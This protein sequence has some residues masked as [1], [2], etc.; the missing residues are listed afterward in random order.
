LPEVSKIIQAFA[1]VAKT[2]HV[3]KIVMNTHRYSQIAVAVVAAVYLM[4]AAPPGLR[5][6]AAESAGAAAPGSATPQSADGKSQGWDV[7]PPCVLS[8]MSTCPPGTEDFDSLDL[9][10]LHLLGIPEDYRS[11]VKPKGVR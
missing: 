5:V 7:K 3:E 8:N 4:A 2:W 9:M 10:P 1:I 6:H 11:A